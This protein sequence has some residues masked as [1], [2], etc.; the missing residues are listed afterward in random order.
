MSHRILG[1]ER[2]SALWSLNTMLCVTQRTRVTE[3][4]W[5]KGLS[6]LAGVCPYCLRGS[7]STLRLGILWEDNCVYQVQGLSVTGLKCYS[8]S[9]WWRLVSQELHPTLF[10]GP[11]PSSKLAIVAT[12]PPGWSWPRVSAGSHTDDPSPGVYLHSP[13]PLPFKRDR[14]VQGHGD[15]PLRLEFL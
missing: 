3:R 6:V 11:G 10:P 13:S 12:N 14:Q 9:S 15:N 7:V 5:D 4:P 1:E 8:R 2:S